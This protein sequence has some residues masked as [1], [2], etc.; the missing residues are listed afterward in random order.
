M[1]DYDKTRKNMTR[2]ATKFP[3][4]PLHVPPREIPLPGFC[5]IWLRSNWQSSRST[6]WFLL[7]CMCVCVT[8]ASRYCAIKL[9]RFHHSSPRL[10]ATQVSLF[11]LQTCSSPFHQ[12][13]TKTNT[14]HM[15]AEGYLSAPET[16][17]KSW[18]RF[19]N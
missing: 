3:L 19:F 5:V 14:C 1:A 15:Q 10:H 8:L 9:M 2:E 12:Q 18:H 16:S 7:S 17:S 4:M 6:G 13:Q 11:L